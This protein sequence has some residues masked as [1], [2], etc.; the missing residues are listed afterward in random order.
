MQV[1]EK[2]FRKGQ[3]QVSSKESPRVGTRWVSACMSFQHM[4]MHSMD[5]LAHVCIAAHDVSHDMQS[6]EEK[7][8]IFTCFKSQ[9]DR[10]HHGLSAS[11]R[12][13]LIAWL[14]VEIWP[15]ALIGFLLL[16]GS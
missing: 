16:L 4:D 8:R 6:R 10:S 9:S 2:E 15:F 13:F 3:A 7:T 5:V 1:R 12:L 11:G 14:V